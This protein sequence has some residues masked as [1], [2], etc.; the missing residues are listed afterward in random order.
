MI[1]HVEY[2]FNIYFAL[3][4]LFEVRVWYSQLMA[5]MQPFLY[6]NGGPIIMVQ[7]ENEYG[8]YYACDNTYKTWLRDETLGHVKDNA[9]LFTNDGPSVLTCGHI[10]GVLA[11]M[12]FG[13]VSDL[14]GTW[15]KLRK[16]QP[17]GPLV[18]AEFYPGWL[19][20]WTEKMARV[21]TK[22]VVNAFV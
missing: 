14:N 15:A 10:D 8:S 1:L 18:N 21:S 12:D 13:G 7:V 3:D 17:K 20:H 5:R 19:T 9:V 22:A 6:G 11:T 16:I 2:I 4:Y